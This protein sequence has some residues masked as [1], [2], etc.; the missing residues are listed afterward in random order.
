MLRTRRDPRRLPA[1]RGRSSPPKPTAGGSKHCS[2]AVTARQNFAANAGVHD[3]FARCRASRPSQDGRRAAFRALGGA[4]IP[5]R[6]RKPLSGQ[7]AR[8]TG[9]V[10]P[11]G[12]GFCLIA[13][14]PETAR[15]VFPTIFLTVWSGFS[16]N[17]P[18][19][20]CRTA[21]NRSRTRSIGRL[22]QHRRDSG[23]TRRRFRLY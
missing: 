16:P 6:P 15:G 20:V 5:R 10:R 19:N 21:R 22:R 12:E 13:K 8:A 23:T 18:A 2:R 11:R 3:L 9:H 14:A 4:A 1:H 7:P 17:L